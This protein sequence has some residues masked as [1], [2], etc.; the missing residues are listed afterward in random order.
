M[1]DFDLNLS[2]IRTFTLSPFRAHHKLKL[3]N[4]IVLT[5]RLLF[6]AKIQGISVLHKRSNSFKQII[7]KKKISKT[8]E[9]HTEFSGQTENRMYSR[10]VVKI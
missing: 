3:K 2:P 1:C 10:K 6:K 8:I 5:N 7:K 9:I 4:K